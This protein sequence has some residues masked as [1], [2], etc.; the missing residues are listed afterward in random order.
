[1]SMLNFCGALRQLDVSVPLERALLQNGSY[2]EFVESFPGFHSF[3]EELNVGDERR[4]F[5]EQGDQWMLCDMF[6]YEPRKFHVKEVH[7]SSLGAFNRIQPCFD[8][9]NYVIVSGDIFEKL[10]KE[11]KER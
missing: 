11:L 8:A 3:T 9:S 1:M 5:I 7:E 2:F 10:K 6:Y 4:V